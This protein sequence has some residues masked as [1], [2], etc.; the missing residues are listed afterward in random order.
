MGLRNRDAVVDAIKKSEDKISDVE[1]WHPNDIHLIPE[2]RSNENRDLHS[3]NLGAWQVGSSKITQIANESDSRVAVLEGDRYATETDGKPYPFGAKFGRN[4]E[5]VWLIDLSNG[6]REK[7]LEKVRFFYGA[8]PTGKRLSW[9]DGK[10]YWIMDVARRARTNVTAKLTGAQKIDFVDR[11]DDHP[12]TVLP[13]NG[14]PVWSK[15]GLTMDA[16]K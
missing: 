8:D 15:D 4:D 11:R 5:Y 6:K 1:I 13:S 12:N 10:D 2:Q 14:A 3:T 7:V 16:N 9:F